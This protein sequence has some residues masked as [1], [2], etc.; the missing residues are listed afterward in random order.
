MLQLSLHLLDFSI[1]INHVAQRYGKLVGT[2][3]EGTGGSVLLS[4]NLDAA[5]VGHLHDDGV[6]GLVAVLS[7]GL[8]R[9]LFF[10]SD[11][12]LIANH[13]NGR[14]ELL[15]ALNLSGEL[16][17]SSSRSRK[18]Q[19]DTHD[20][21]AILAVVE[22]LPQ[23][24]GNERHEGVQHHEQLFEEL[25]CLIVGL[26]VDRLCLAIDVGRLHHLQIPAGELIPEELIDSHQGLRD[27]ILLEQVVHLSVGLLQLSLKPSGS[28][29]A[30]L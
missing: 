28:N 29:L 8:Q 15:D 19:A 14:D 17:V 7:N 1:H 24:L 2:N 4:N 13:T 10:R 18:M 25:Q 26:L 9:E 22:V 6:E 20:A 21:L 23:L 11:V 30:S 12:L 27:T 5:Q 3:H 16:V